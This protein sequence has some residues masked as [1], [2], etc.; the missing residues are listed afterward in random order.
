[1]LKNI[2]RKNNS[3]FCIFEFSL[4]KDVT[5][6]LKAKQMNKAT[7]AKTLLEQRQREEAKERAEKSLKWQTKVRNSRMKYSLNLI[8]YFSISLNLVN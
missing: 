2:D 1:M 3:Q 4:W 7:S 5:F 6:Y 8:V